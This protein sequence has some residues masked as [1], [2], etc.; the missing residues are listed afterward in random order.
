MGLFGSVAFDRLG[1]EVRRA[2][3]QVSTTLDADGVEA[4]DAGVVCGVL[5][6]AL[7]V[8]WWLGRSLLDLYST[9]CRQKRQ[10][11]N[12]KKKKET[13]AR[14][15]YRLLRDKLKSRTCS[16]ECALHWYMYALGQ[17]TQSPYGDGD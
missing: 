6:T 8:V 10:P 13:R 7:N 5:P 14:L 15:L 3:L 16:G 9:L 1:V 17:L 4:A 2:S 12:R 11:E